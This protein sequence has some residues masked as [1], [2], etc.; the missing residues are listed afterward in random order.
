MAVSKTPAPPIQKIAP[1]P[2]SLAAQQR[3]AQSAQI[4]AATAPAP[5]KIPLEETVRKAVET[6]RGVLV[7]GLDTEGK[8]QVSREE[9]VRKGREKIDAFAAE[10]A[11]MDAFLARS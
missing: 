10:I 6:R 11:D 5:I 4:A 2:S 7:N 8:L 3:A 9:E 1:L